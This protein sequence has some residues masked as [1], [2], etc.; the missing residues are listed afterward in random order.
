MHKFQRKLNSFDQVCRFEQ[1]LSK[2]SRVNLNK[3]VSG[4][5]VTILIRNPREPG[6]HQ[7]P[8]VQPQTYS[9][10]PSPPFWGFVSLFLPPPKILSCKSKHHSYI[11]MSNIEFPDENF[12]KCT[13]TNHSFTKIRYE[14]STRSLFWGVKFEIKKCT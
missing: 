1:L 8:S 3:P 10:P 2:F 5:V 11:Y 12:Q 9:L 13:S 4:S 14:K 6:L 7:H